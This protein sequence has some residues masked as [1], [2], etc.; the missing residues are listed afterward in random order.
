M[1]QFADSGTV[2][3]VVLIGADG[4]RSRTRD[5]MDAAPQ[6]R[7]RRPSAVGAPP[8]ARCPRSG[9]I[10]RALSTGDTRDDPDLVVSPNPFL[11]A[12]ADTNYLQW[13]R[14]RTALH[15]R[16]HH[17]R[18][19]DVA[20]SSLA[21]GGFYARWHAPTL[22]CLKGTDG[23]DVAAVLTS[24]LRGRARALSGGVAVRTKEEKKR[25]RRWESP[26]REPLS[27]AAR[28]AS[29]RRRIRSRLRRRRLKVSA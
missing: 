10:R 22:R 1:L 14:R 4:I 19:F 2:S 7:R 29:R 6:P 25:R 26:L 18:H 17:P 8:Q 28:A 15:R 9:G 16:V 3:D 27:R 13:Q 5:L 20:P 21:R 11:S 23:L 12:S 24:E